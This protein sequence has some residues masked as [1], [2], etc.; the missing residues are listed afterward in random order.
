MVPVAPRAAL[1]TR[2]I[3][4]ITAVTLF[5]GIFCAWLAA[6]NANSTYLHC[7]QLIALLPGFQHSTGSMSSVF[8]SV[9]AVMA[10]FV[11]LFQGAAC[12]TG[13]TDSLPTCAQLKAL[14]LCG[15]LKGNGLCITTCGGCNGTSVNPP[16][17]QR[18]PPPPSPAKILPPPPR[19]R[20]HPPPFPNGALSGATA[21][22]GKVGDEACLCISRFR[23]I[24]MQL[25]H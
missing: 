18:H 13:C 15:S 1:R 8:M 10:L 22:Y 14:G 21:E 9:C 12:A 16:P 3:I 23:S 19:P 25:L 24:T 6:S 11:A 5:P 2:Y 20:P 4:S 17:L 7:K